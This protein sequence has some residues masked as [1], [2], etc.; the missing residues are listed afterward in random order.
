LYLNIKIKNKLK[1]KQNEEN[2]QVLLKKY[3]CGNRIRKFKE[4]LSLN[5]RINGEFKN[6]L[7]GLLL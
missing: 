7:S 3:F 1:L 4:N 5:Q 2:E 6:K